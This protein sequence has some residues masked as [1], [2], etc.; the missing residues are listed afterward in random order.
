MIQTYHTE[1]RDAPNPYHI[2]EKCNEF[3]LIHDTTSHWVKEINII[4]IWAVS[5]NGEIFKVPFST[6]K[7][8]GSFT[9]K[10][11][12]TKLIKEIS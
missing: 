1:N 8:P 2:L 11:T 5:S 6:T 3:N 4:F 7:V 9:G 10:A 12:C